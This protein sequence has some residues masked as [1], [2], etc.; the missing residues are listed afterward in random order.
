[1]SVYVIT[2]KI[3]DKHFKY[4]IE[5][6]HYLMVGANRCSERKKDYLYDDKGDNI[7]EKNPNYCELTGLYWIWKNVTDEYVGLVH[8]RRYFTKHSLFSNSKYFYSDNELKRLLG[9]NDILLPER[10]YVAS[11]NMYD[12]YCLYHYQKDIDLLKALIE[13]KHSQYNHAF[14]IVFSRNYFNP[15]NM[16]YCKKEIIDQYCSWLFEVLKEYEKLVDISDYNKDQARIF[17]FIAER[18]FNVW[19]EYAGIKKKEIGWVQTDAS[20][21]HRLRKKAD[22]IAKRAIREHGKYEK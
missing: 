1:M 18:L 19:V 22:K 16:F 11:P 20:I 10:M 14:D 3:L 8:Y 12:N 21:Q 13:Q 7:S 15:G 4:D 6:Y 5:G 9:E 17:G 2:H